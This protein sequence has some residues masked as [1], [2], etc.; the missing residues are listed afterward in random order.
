MKTKQK[1]KY[2]ILLTI[3][4]LLAGIVRFWKLNNIPPGVWYDE[5][6]NALDA[7]R[8]EENHDWKIFY[9]EN[10]GREGL[11]I[12]IL[13]LSFKIFGINNFAL[14]FP[15]ALIGFLTVLGFYLLLR[16]FKLKRPTI[17]LGSFALATSF[18]HLNFSRIAF[19]AILVP[20]LLV[21][22]FYFFYKGL[23]KYA[24]VIQQKQN[25]HHLTETSQIA[26]KVLANFL[27][28]GLITGLGLHTYIAY[29]VAPLI[30]VILLV[31]FIIA[32]PGFLKHYKKAIALFLIGAILSAGPLLWYFYN[33]PSAFTGRTDAVS[34]FNAPDMSFLQAFSKSLIYHL[35]SFVLIG[36]QNQRH[37]Y[38]GLPLLPAV[39]SLFFL[40]GWAISA[41]E[42]ILGLKQRLHQKRISRK[43]FSISL[44]SQAIFWTM[45]IPGVLSLEGIPHA[46]RIIGVIP[47]LFIFIALPFE[48]LQNLY[49]RLKKSPF[50]KIRLYRWKLMQVSFVGL[51]LTFVLTGFGQLYL[52]FQLWA[53][54]PQTF[55]A[56][57]GDL[58]A[59]GQIIKQQPLKKENYIL[60][61]STTPIINVPAENSGEKTL[62]F[63]AYP[64]IKDYRL[65]SLG[66]VTE[67]T[68]TID[69]SDSQIVLKPGLS[70]DN[71]QVIQNYCRNLHLEK[72]VF[73]N[74]NNKVEVWILK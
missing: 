34:I 6:Y 1:T 50:Y 52:Y 42:I 51:M 56:F 8:A 70:P 47:A 9:P 57:Q 37:N 3:I 38:N 29:R 32:Y 58:Y 28:A 49:L 26:G 21:W 73:T 63:S 30:F 54:N 4:L 15:G 40:I 68:K 61:D 67:M 17:L 7:I 2:L 5:A 20:F 53:N 41:R 24:M 35:Q 39:W 19:R 12:N 69:C 33:N 59:L 74:L 55:E 31:F 22:S 62:V 11:Y 36:D 25:K 16:Q 13:S 18:Y 60:I 66:A 71:L 43:L 44:L 27:L 45:L 64:I 23:R 46:L 48:Y 65:F 14:R 72:E 10:Y